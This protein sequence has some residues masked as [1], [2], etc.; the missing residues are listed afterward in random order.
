MQF[1]CF[2]SDINR[3]M[4]FRCCLLCNDRKKHLCVIRTLESAEKSV[5]ELSLLRRRLWIPM[6]AIKFINL[7]IHNVSS[8][9][10]PEL[11]S[12]LVLIWFRCWVGK[13]TFR[14][15]VAQL[16]AIS[17]VQQENNLKVYSDLKRELYDVHWECNNEF[18][19]TVFGGIR[20]DKFWLKLKYE[21]YSSKYCKLTGERDENVKYLTVFAAD[22][23]SQFSTI[24][25]NL[26]DKSSCWNSHKMNFRKKI[27]IS[28]F[29]WWKTEQFHSKFTSISR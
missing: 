26:G 19:L 10:L 22:F 4:E 12:F 24:A 15:I 18:V 6:M 23:E 5:S 25:V 20:R 27:F 13:L 11:N 21:N 1:L 14:Q 3:Y 2:D 28:A 8:N 7:N 16:F 17:F 29:F 9:E